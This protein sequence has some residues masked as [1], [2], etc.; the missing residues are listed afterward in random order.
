MFAF[1]KPFAAASYSDEAW[2]GG[3]VG[4]KTALVIGQVAGYGLAKFAGIKFCSEAPRGRRASLL[5]T[6][7]L[8]AE[9]AL[10]LFAVL[11]DGWRPLAMLLNGAPLGMVW[12]LVVWYLEGR[13]TSEILLAGVS[14]S[15]IVAS[16]AV[17]D[18]GRA[19]LAGADLPLFGLALPNPFPPLDETWM[20]AAVG[21]LFL[22]PFFA[23]VWMLDRLPEPD[24]RDVALRSPRATMDNRSRAAFIRRFWPG[25]ALLLAAYFFITAFRDFRD[26]Y[27]VELY[28]ELDYPY[29][30]NQSIITQSESYVGL[31]VA[32]VLALLYF[33]RDNRRGL[34]AVFAVMAGGVALLGGATWLRQQGALSG[35]WWMTLVGLGS[36]LAYVPY[37][38]VLFDRVIASTRVAGTAVFAIY[39]ADTLGYM[40]TITVLLTKDYWVGDATRLE[41]LESF[42]YALSLGGVVCLTLAA[43]YFRRAAAPVGEWSPSAHVV[44]ASSTA[45]NE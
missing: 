25:M 24:A 39:V 3:S 22:A 1:R 6:M 11:P 30:Q 31:G 5:F 41:F 43:A 9:A 26:N 29:L 16:G 8:A 4:L 42:A 20:P 7:V 13:R 44:H 32:A 12:G 21:A 40:G 45:R 17:K 15:F 2:L 14:C 35:F 34:A 23:A 27:S 36:Y 33:V 38:S 18:I 19:V 28:A 37:G 10:C